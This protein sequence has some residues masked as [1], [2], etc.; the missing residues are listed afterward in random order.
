[1]IDGRGQPRITDFGLA[2]LAAEI[3]LSDLRSGTPAYMSPEQKAGREVT[4]RSDIYSLGLVMYEMFTG[5]A[6]KDTQSS[7]SEVVKDL[8]PAIERVILRCLDEEPKRRPS[9]ALAVAMGLPG[10]DPIAAA[11]AAGETPSPEMV[12]ASQEKEGFSAQTAVLC[13]SLFLT[14][15]FASE[16]SIRPTLLTTFAEIETPPDAMA[17]HAK[18]IL[19]QLGYTEPAAHS[20]YGFDCCDQSNLNF[21]QGQDRVRRDRL[22]ANHRPAVMHFWYRQHRDEFWFAP[23]PPLNAAAINY[24]NP[25]NTEP[26][27]IR[28]AVDGKER[29]I[30]L[31]VRPWATSKESNEPS[32]PVDEV[33]PLLLAAGELDTNQLTPVAPR[34]IP[35]MAFD[36]QAAWE[37]PLE[38][39]HPEK[40]HVE[41]A[42]WRGRPVFF[43]VEG[44]WHE[45]GL[46]PN[47]NI[48]WPFKLFFILASVAA[49]VGAALTARHNLR[50]GRGDRQGAA[51]IATTAA[52]LLTASMLL[53]V[54]HVA[55]F[56]EL[57]LIVEIVSSGLFAGANLW[58]AYIAVE[59]YMR[60]NW[61]DSLISWTRLQS[62]RWR[63][64][65][66]A[67][68]VLVGM[69]AMLGGMGLLAL[70]YRLTDSP[71]FS[72]PLT[73]LDSPSRFA[74]NLLSNASGRILMAMILMVL[75]VLV[76]LMVRRVWL[77]DV[78]VALLFGVF[79]IPA[80]SSSIRF[81][82]AA[83]SMYVLLWVL[84]RYGLVAFVAGW[85]TDGLIESAPSSWTGWYSAYHWVTLAILIGIAVWA[86]RV[87][88]AEKR[89]EIPA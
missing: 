87:V 76:R 9:T 4:V 78:V 33:W 51:A 10:G 3:P 62:G 14:V 29:L 77:A 40:I 52:L 8:D 60:R 82:A 25:E 83:L 20:L 17:Y 30:A 59:P 2:G 27:M 12:A 48:A 75:M 38:A 5:K 43:E 80:Q 26:G 23:S 7:P 89:S 35:P 53:S 44:E 63:D 86:L 11:L 68:H 18:E 47:A 22:L 6:R 81:A 74:A 15:L 19:K 84:R 24:S 46:A 16:W 64:P 36:A 71:L 67:S 50:A 37:G 41:A 49:I 1:M 65:L 56:W 31:E 73:S 61:P 58:L 70:V 39:G 72:S 28:M 66:V 32:K 79:W 69:A 57:G 42:S 54:H 21:A 85:I 34:G 13:F 88:L 45:E 55:S